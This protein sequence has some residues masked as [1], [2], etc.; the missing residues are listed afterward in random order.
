M[1][2]PIVFPELFLHYIWKLKLFNFKVLKTVCGQAIELVHVGKHNHA[3]GPDFMNAR[4]RIGKTL[5]AGSV[6]IHKKSSDWLVHQHQHD[7]AYNN[8]ILHVVY[9]QDKAIYRATGELLPTLELKNRIAPQYIQRYWTLWNNETWIPCEKQVAKVPMALRILWLDALVVERLEHKMAAIESCLKQNKNN[10]EA[11]FYLFLARCFGAKQNGQSFEALTQ[12]LPL[13][14]LSKHKSNLFELEALLLGQAG[15]LAEEERGKEDPY[16][17]KLIKEYTFLAKKYQLKPLKASC[18]KF[19]GIRPANFPTLRLAQ[20]ALLV[21]QSNHL[22]SKILEESNV[23]QL[24]VLFRVSLDGYWNHHYRLGVLSAKRNKTL[25]NASIDLILINTIAPFLFAFGRYKDEKKYQERA[26]LL[27]QDIPAE[28]N[29]II[30]HWKGIGIGAKS[31]YETQALLQL[32]TAYC[33][34]KHCLNCS[35]GHEIL[36]MD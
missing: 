11:T 6:E 29:S 8:T 35:I 25:G 36:K 34:P 18:W 4:I 27:L 23:E 21:H 9:E 17:Q 2:N 26:L 7:R 5:W 13:R 24:R 30:D 1:S 19:G 20:F 16:V 3:S 15:F 14:I 22:F 32:K 12:S 28:K 10:W 31:A 33:T